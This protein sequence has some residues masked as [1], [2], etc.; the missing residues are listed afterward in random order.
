MGVNYWCFDN[1]LG[2]IVNILIKNGS[3]LGE[4]ELNLLLTY[5]KKILLIGDVDIK[6]ERLFEVRENS[7]VIAN[8]EIVPID[9]GYSIEHKRV[10]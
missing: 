7:L 2:E 9:E 8:I 5:A 1:I 4:K 3:A 10:S 6:K